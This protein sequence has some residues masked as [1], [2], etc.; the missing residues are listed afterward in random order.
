MRDGVDQPDPRPAAV[1]FITTE[2]FTLQGARAATI[3]ESTGRATVFLGSVSGGL[4]A[5]GLLGQ[6]SHLGGAFYGFGLIV[7]P[8]LAFLGLVTFHRVFQSGREDAA[9][10]ARIAHLRAF[11][12][13]VAPE[14]T[15]YMLSVPPERRLEVQGLFTSAAQKF[16]TIAG[17]VA[18]IT[19]VLTGA[20]VG[21]LGAVV[22]SHSAALA[23]SVGGAT[24]TATLTVMVRYLAA[25]MARPL[26]IAGAEDGTS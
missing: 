2:H 13:D 25:Q 15:P 16:L 21:L 11:Y 9:Y 1:T 22:S 7:L 6:A 26:P 3:A 19:S 23:F 18:V 10:A 14:L 5:L 17:T 4:I 8:T 12:F 24:T 20:T